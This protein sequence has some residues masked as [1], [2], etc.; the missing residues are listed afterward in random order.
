MNDF[1]V[2]YDLSGQNTYYS[3]SVNIG[4]SEFVIFGEVLS[5]ESVEYYSSIYNFS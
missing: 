4:I 3:Y 1:Q 2:N 5:K